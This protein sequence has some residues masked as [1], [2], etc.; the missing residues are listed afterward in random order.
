[1]LK[2]TK[3]PHANAPV[4]L[5]Y[6]IARDFEIDENADG[7]DG[8][9][10]TG[11]ADEKEDG[12]VEKG[13]EGE[14]TDGEK[15]VKVDKSMT[16]SPA[17]DIA[18]VGAKTPTVKTSKKPKKQWSDGEHKRMWNM[19]IWCDKWDDIYGIENV[20]V[21]QGFFIDKPV[22]NPLDIIS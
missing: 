17:T 11:S 16:Q 15:N 21:G 3:V 5:N 6:R 1:M 9:D 19:V 12:T 18:K 2:F 22:A 10:S 14:K 20:S 8:E 4:E 7:A 13:E